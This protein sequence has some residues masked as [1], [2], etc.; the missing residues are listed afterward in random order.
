MQTSSSN[1][2]HFLGALPLQLGGFDDRGL[3]I[4]NEMN[5]Q[6]AG[7]LLALDRL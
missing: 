4:R 7:G 1:H 6:L 2:G 3:V 5:A